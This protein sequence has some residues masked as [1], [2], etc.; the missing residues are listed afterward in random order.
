[1]SRALLLL[2]SLWVLAAAGE[3]APLSPQAF[4]D[5]FAAA[6]ATATGHA[7]KPIDD[8]TFDAKSSDGSDITIN[9][10]NAYAAYRADPAQLDA[11]IGRYTRTLAGTEDAG[12]DATDQ[13]IVIVRPSDYLAR[14]LPSG[15]QT[16]GFV[17]PRPMAGDLSYFLAVDSPE[18]IRTAGKSD[19]ARWHIDEATAWKIAIGNLGA[20]VGS[21]SVLHLGADDGANGIG[22]ASG[23]APSILADPTY[24]AKDSP[25]GANGEI[26]LLYAK[27][28]FL[29]TI[30]ADK[31]MTSR[32]WTSVKA[33]IGAGRSLSSTPLACRDGRWQAVPIP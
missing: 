13:L 21:I 10:D 19:L 23:L 20:R 26:I 3:P 32:F 6:V 2:A 18:S 14:N 33:E 22:A 24:C 15:S 8:Y 9:T 7:T 17:A 1:M 27:D 29:F 16:G 30:P 11:I 4:R 12:H 25:A 5:R 31:A 28:F